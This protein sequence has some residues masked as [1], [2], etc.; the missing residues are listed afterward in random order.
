MTGLEGTGSDEFRVW[1]DQVQAQFTEVVTQ[2]EGYRLWRSG[3]TVQEAVD[4]I[5][6]DRESV[7]EV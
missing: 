3:M 7:Y 1:F 5:R 2:S 6:E 4:T